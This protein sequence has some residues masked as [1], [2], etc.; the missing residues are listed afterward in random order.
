MRDGQSLWW[1]R[2]NRA[3]WLIKQI[4]PL[5]YW[6]TSHPVV[7]GKTGKEEF[8]IWRMWLGHS[9]DIVRFKQA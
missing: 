5:T 7:A 4:L 1:H 6:T 8:I 3:K 9:F 2:K